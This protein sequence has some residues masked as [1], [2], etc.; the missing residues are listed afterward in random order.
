MIKVGRM[1]FYILSLVSSGFIFFGRYFISIWAGKDFLEAYAV[2]L[3]L[4]IPGTIS[5][6]QSI[7]IEIQRARNMHKFR[8]IAY[9]IMA[10]LNI[11]VSLLLVR[12]LGMIGCAIGTAFS[13]IIGNGL[14]MNWYYQKKMNL[15]MWLFWKNILSIGKGLCIPVLFGIA[16]S[17]I[18]C[19]SIIRFL[20]MI[21]SYTLIFGVSNYL[22]SFN[23]EERAEV[24]Q[25]LSKFRRLP[26]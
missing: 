10:I 7:G 22:F 21:V 19:N 3:L 8:S 23:K 9:F 2:V 13:L 5:L 25:I 1:Q 26:I 4:I 12:S 17:F 14:I 6:C 16:C 24:S 15:N 18:G 11:I 20:I